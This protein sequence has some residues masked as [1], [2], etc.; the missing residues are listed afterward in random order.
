[1]NRK[2]AEKKWKDKRFDS[3]MTGVNEVFNGWS[4]DEHVRVCEYWR[5]MPTE[6]ELAVYPN[7]K[8][9]DLTDDEYEPEK[10]GYEGDVP[11]S[12]EREPGEQSQEDKPTHEEKNYRPGEGERRCA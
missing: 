7:G 10:E 3:P 6:R 1:M 5:K 11:Y 8:I 2:R 4:T 12:G 9:V